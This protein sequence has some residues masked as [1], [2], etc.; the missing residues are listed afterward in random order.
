MRGRGL[1]MGGGGQREVS[2]P[3]KEDTILGVGKAAPEMALLV[4][5]LKITVQNHHLN[6]SSLTLP[7]KYLSWPQ[8]FL[9]QASFPATLPITH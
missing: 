9:S 2:E 3:R 1:V 5:I 4:M 7:F 8:L 6:T